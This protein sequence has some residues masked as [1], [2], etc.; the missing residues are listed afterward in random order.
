M[1]PLEQVSSHLTKLEQRMRWTAMSKGAAWIPGVGL[2]TTVLL[3]I[4]LNGFAVS[5]GS[6]LLACRRGVH[7]GLADSERTWILGSRC[8]GPLGGRGAERHGCCILRH[9]REPWEQERSPQGRP[10]GECPID[11]F[12][13]RTRQSL[14]QVSE[15]FQVGRSADVAAG[16]GQR[17]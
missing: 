2:L 10:V 4:L 12:P 5:T 8:V 9:Y 6:L 13:G 11:G 14:R 15:R 16:F 7:F 3:G 17:F 1:N